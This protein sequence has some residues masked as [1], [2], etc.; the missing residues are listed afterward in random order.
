[1][2]ELLERRPVVERLRFLGK[3]VSVVVDFDDVHSYVETAKLAFEERLPVITFESDGGLSVHEILSKVAEHVFSCSE[4][5]E[6]IEPKTVE[7]Y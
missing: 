3:D 4:C 6:I 7:G 2:K 1:M 5:R